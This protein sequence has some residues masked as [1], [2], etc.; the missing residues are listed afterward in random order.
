AR[1]PHNPHTPWTLMAPTGSSIESFSNSSTAN[2]TIPPA[3]APIMI[4][5]PG[6]TVAQDAVIPTRPA[7]TPLSAMLISGLPTRNQVVNIATDAPAQADRFVLIAMSPKAL[8]AP[9]PGSAP[10]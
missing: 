5:L 4:A 8:P 2:T 7:K 1:V 3:I 6:L 9:A 10:P